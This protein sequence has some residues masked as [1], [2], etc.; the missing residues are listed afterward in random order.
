M[1]QRERTRI[2]SDN[3][4]ELLRKTGKHAIFASADGSRKLIVP[5]GSGV[6]S[7]N[8]RNLLAEI[9][10]LNRN[11]SYNPPGLPMPT[12]QPVVV[13]KIIINPV[14]PAPKLPTPIEK[15]MQQSHVA[16]TFTSY[17]PDYLA[18]LE[19]RIKQLITAGCT[20]KEAAIKLNEEGFKNT[21]GGPFNQA[22]VGNFRMKLGLA[23]P[24]AKVA[25]KKA[26][27]EKPAPTPALFDTAPKKPGFIKRLP[28]TAVAILTDPE[29][30]A[31]QKVDMLMA[32]AR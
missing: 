24:S 12:P 3:G 8:E 25:E 13:P 10:R 17:R 1:N 29:L 4:L 20:S 19:N 30:T 27:K 7:R 2:L 16:K 5:T 6:S 23:K 21:M 32:Y 31:G 18:K 15:P 14:A 11:V 22:N 9:K 28:E 26:P